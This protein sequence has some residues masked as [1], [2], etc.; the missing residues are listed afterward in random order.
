MMTSHHQSPSPGIE[1]KPPRLKAACWWMCPA[2]TVAV[3]RQLHGHAFQLPPS[4]APLRNL[5]R[6]HRSKGASGKHCIALV[7]YFRTPRPWGMWCQTDTAHMAG[8][9][10]SCW[11]GQ[12]PSATSCSL[13]CP[14]FQLS[15][16]QGVAK[17]E[18]PGAGLFLFKDIWSGT[19]V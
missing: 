5:L 16:L 14:F 11:D 10:A 3:L 8:W 17:G 6:T 7:Q 9:Q 13:W 18:V 12:C 2:F 19:W 15:A 4:I 1:R